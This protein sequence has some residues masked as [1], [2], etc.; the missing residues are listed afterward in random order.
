MEDLEKL[1]ETERKKH[2][3]EKKIAIELSAKYF[4]LRNKQMWDLFCKLKFL[5]KY[6]FEVKY[7]NCDDIRLSKAGCPDAQITIVWEN[8]KIGKET[9]FWCNENAYWV[10]W[11]ANCCHSENRK[12][13][14][15]SEEELIKAIAEKM[16]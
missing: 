2:N 3:D 8:K 1:F 13:L 11:R 12:N 16:R 9:Y 15:T 7:C 5:E 6:G 14:F 4:R 10:D